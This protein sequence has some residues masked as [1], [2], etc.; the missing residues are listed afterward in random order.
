LFLSAGR[1]VELLRAFRCAYKELGLRG[2]VIG[3]DIDPLAPAL[4]VATRAYVV[5]RLDTPDFLPALLAICRA[6]RVDLIFPLIDP[7]IPVLARNRAALV[8]VGAYPAVISEEAAATTADKWRTVQLFDRLAVPRPRSWLPGELD[9]GCAEYPL[10]IKPRNGS[11]GKSAFTVRNAQELTFFA[12]YVPDPII[13]EHVPGPEITSDVVCDLDGEV[14]AVI[15]RKRLEVRGGEVSKGVT[16]FSRVIADSCVDIAR[17][18]PAVGP[19]TVQCLMKDSMPLF[20]EINARLG[21]GFPL[22]IHAGLDSPR[23]LL[24]RAAG[25][26]VEIPPLGSYRRG[27]YLTRFDDGFYLTEAERE[28]MASRRL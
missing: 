26:G 17:A 19:V 2:E 23:L 4:H 3:V 8:A 25:L 1:R 10:F 15:S 18:L 14:L 7:D 5:P 22:G 11:A 12:E 13:Q 28:Q 21:G 9:P 27:V 16:V 6:E 20:T 24:A